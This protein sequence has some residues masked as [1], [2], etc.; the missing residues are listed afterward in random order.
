MTDYYGPAPY[1]WWNWNDQG[2]SYVTGCTN[3]V[4]YTDTN[5]KGHSQGFAGNQAQY[6]D[7]QGLRLPN[8]S[9]SSIRISYGC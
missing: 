3:G 2:S 4:F 6:L 8:D 7:G 1:Y 5:Q 9:L